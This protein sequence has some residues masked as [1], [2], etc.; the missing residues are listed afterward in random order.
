MSARDKRAVALL[1]VAALILMTACSL[2]ASQGAAAVPPTTAPEMP[3]TAAPE[4]ELPTWTPTAAASATPAG[5]TTTL[6]VVEQ[7]MGQVQR[8]TPIAEWRGVPVMPGALDG[9]DAESLY[10]FSTMAPPAEVAAW[11]RQQLGQR[12]WAPSYG[13]SPAPIAG[14]NLVMYESDSQRAFISAQ[15]QEGKT[16]V[17]LDITNK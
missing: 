12:G 17:L 16:L 4:G 15:I 2:L 6:S 13:D 14:A 8:G 5:P 11:Y 10:T 1:G 9:T 3:T 7:M